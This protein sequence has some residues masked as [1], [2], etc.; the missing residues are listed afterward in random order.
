MSLL[1]IFKSYQDSDFLKLQK[2]SHIFIFFIKIIFLKTPLAS[3]FYVPKFAQ[4][5]KV[6]KLPSQILKF[7][8]RKRERC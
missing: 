1:Y 3:S 2:H 6:L 8:E 4:N 5:A 7:L